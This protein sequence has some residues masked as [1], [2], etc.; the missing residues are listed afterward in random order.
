[1]LRHLPAQRIA[2][3]LLAV[4]RCLLRVDLLHQCRVDV[5]QML[6]GGQQDRKE[7]GVRSLGVKGVLLIE[8]LET[9]QR[10]PLVGESGIGVVQHRVGVFA[11]VA[12]WGWRS[13][14]VWG[15]NRREMMRMMLMMRAH[16][17]KLC[18][19]ERKS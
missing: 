15:R 5:D 17:V 6:A 1:M 8:A 9:V 2:R 4:Q 12:R 10:G 16:C 14:G 13:D 3:R 18:R 11:A 19:G 7:V